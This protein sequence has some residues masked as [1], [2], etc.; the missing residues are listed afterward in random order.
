MKKKEFL[1]KYLNYF[2]ILLSVFIGLFFL[3]YELVGIAN[4]LIIFSSTIILTTIL[5]LSSKKISASNTIMLPIIIIDGFFHLTSPLEN[6]VENSPD[7][8]IAFNLYG[9]KGMP[10]IIHQIMGIFLITTSII[11]IYYLILKKKKLYFYFYKYLISI[12]TMVIIC[13]SYLIKI[14]N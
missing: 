5:I 7:W 1:L 6:L 10:A 9:G 2:I 3:I 14:Y 12:I 8:I 13:F 4:K 11:F